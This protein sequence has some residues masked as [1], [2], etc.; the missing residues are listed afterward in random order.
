MANYGLKTNLQAART[1]TSFFISTLLAQQPED[2]G[3]KTVFEYR[4]L[5]K[6]YPTPKDKSAL[7]REI[8]G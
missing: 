4:M 8:R 7:I 3:Q 1:S 6:E 2:R 5:N